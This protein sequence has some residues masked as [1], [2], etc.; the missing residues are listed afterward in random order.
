MLGLNDN[1]LDW[2]SLEWFSL[3]TLRSFDWVYPLVLYA[4]P[5]VPSSS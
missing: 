5:V 1:M 3:S 2:L 4:L